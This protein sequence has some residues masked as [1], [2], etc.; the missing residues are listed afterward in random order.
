[1]VETVE[2]NVMGTVHTLTALAEAGTGRIVAISSGSVYGRREHL[3]PIS[4]DDAKDPPALYAMTKWAGDMLARRLALVRGLDVAVA[5]LASPFGPFERDT[6]SRPLLSPIAHW[7]EAAVK[8]Q[9][10]VVT[11]DATAER[12]VVYVGDIAGG[13]AGILLADR[14]AHDSYNVGWGRGTSAEEA[15]A[16]LR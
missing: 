7:A 15:V 1:F 3:S 11:G 14:L 5:R 2:A 10:V 6:G 13:I 8:G 12:D 16:A 4:E 9:P